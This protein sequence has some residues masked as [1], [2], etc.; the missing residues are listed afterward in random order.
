MKKWPALALIATVLTSVL[1]VA[2]A[3][4][5]D[6][7]DPAPTNV[8]ISWAADGSRQVHVTWDETAPRPNRIAVRDLDKAANV[9]AGYTT[10][11]APNSI[12]LPADLFRN[13]EHLQVMVA[14]GTRD[15]LT[16]PE[17]PSVTFDSHYPSTEVDGVTLAPTGMTVKARSTLPQDTTPGDPLDNDGTSYEPKYR[18]DF[19]T[20]SLAP[21]GP[22][23]EVF[24][25]HPASNYAFFLAAHSRWLPDAWNN[26]VVV[27]R[28]RVTAQAPARWQ[29]GSE[30]SVTGSYGRLLGTYQPRVILHARNSPTSPWYVV[31]TTVASSEGK[32]SLSFLARTRE[33]R[34][35]MASS[36]TK[37]VNWTAFVGGSTAPMK[38]V[39]Y[40]RV[41]GLFTTPTIKVGQTS[42]VHVQLNVFLPTGLVALQRWNGKTWVFVQNIALKDNVGWAKVTGKAVGSSTYRIYSPNVTKDG[43]LVAAA[44][45]P[46]FTL[47]V[48]R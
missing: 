17:G 33:Y 18:L 9:I 46:N 28:P 22:A 3:F 25:T 48:S 24:V 2:E 27:D 38:S 41:Y 1:P 23:T 8:Q 12:D 39:A 34:I 43:M 6:L 29:Y 14:A 32:F 47:K 21:A 45:S 16:S 13:H 20:Y 36:V 37:V 35:A 7:P 15:G 31:M 4:A 44:Y 19:K 42:N 40:Q 10:V 5:A 30:M 26:E 11:E